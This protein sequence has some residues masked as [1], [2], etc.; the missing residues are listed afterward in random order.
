MAPV[1][2]VKLQGKNILC[3]E[4]NINNLLDCNTRAI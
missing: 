3:T 1:D 4:T 2:Y